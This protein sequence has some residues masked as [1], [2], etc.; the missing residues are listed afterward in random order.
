[1]QISLVDKA[2]EVKSSKISGTGVFTNRSFKKG[3]RV[4]VFGGFVL[5]VEEF[6]ALKDSDR[7]VYDTIHEVGYQVDDDA[8]FSPVS[9]SQFSAIEYLNHSCEPT[10]GFGSAIHLVAMQDIEEGEE[11]TMDYATCIS[12]DIFEIED[13]SCKSSICRKIVTANDW[14]NPVLQNKYNGF[15]QPYLARKIQVLNN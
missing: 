9:A 15:F 11:V 8:I 6:V 4:A 13:C 7:N 14:K 5:S 10:C 1:M 3:E 12:L 2:L